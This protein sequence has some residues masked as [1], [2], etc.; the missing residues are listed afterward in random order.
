MAAKRLP[1][2]RAL[3]PTQNTY[4][5]HQMKAKLPMMSLASVLEGY[6]LVYKRNID[7]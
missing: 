3:V 6:P 2:V 1:K 7:I 4:G 5:G